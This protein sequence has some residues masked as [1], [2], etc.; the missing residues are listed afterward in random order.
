MQQAKYK[1]HKLNKIEF[2]IK[3]N[4]CTNELKNENLVKKSDYAVAISLK[5]F[6]TSNTNINFIKHL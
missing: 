5:L 2:H 6:C 1:F 3:N 4:K